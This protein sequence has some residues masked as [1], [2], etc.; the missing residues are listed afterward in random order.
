MSGRRSARSS[1]WRVQG[2]SCVLT[3]RHKPE[4]PLQLMALRS[5]THREGGMDVFDNIRVLIG[6]RVGNYDE[7]L[8]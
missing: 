4:K 3:N 1:R 8:E 2:R 7:L 6:L 5:V